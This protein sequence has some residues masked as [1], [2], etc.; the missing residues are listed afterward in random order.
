MVIFSNGR[1]HDDQGPAVPQDCGAFLHG[2]GV[3][4][5]LR[6]YRGEPRHFEE[7]VRRLADHAQ[8]LGLP[9][10]PSLSGLQS[11][12]SELVQRNS[13]AA[14]DS[15]L[16]ITWTMAHQAGWLGVVPGPLPAELETWQR[17]GVAVI[18]LG[19][20]YQ[21]SFRPDL[22]SV[23]YLPSLLALKE[24][25]AAS[26]CAEALVFDDEGYLL[27]GAV[28]N[29]FVVEDGNVITPPADG[30]ILAGLT[31][32]RVLQR[33]DS[34]GLPHLEASLTQDQVLQAQEVFLTNS[35]REV[36]PVIAVDGHTI[37]SGRP[38]PVTRSLQCN[39]S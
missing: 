4:T 17:R 37:G 26:G 21:R 11:I 38:G 13:L 24:A 20:E 9:P 30:R 18:T 28:S 5:T 22:K 25:E 39:M 36:V 35:V 23:N 32:Q 12:I 27:E 29:V 31:R 1:Y 2:Y 16:R 6:L 3:F 10:G 34:L 19:S 15:R 8:A 33:A 14:A 7:H